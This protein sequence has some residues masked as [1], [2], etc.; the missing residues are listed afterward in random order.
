MMLVWAYKSRLAYKFGY[1]SMAESIYI[2]MESIAEAHRYSYNVA[3]YYHYGA[4][5]FYER[6]RETRQRKHTPQARKYKKLLE[7]IKRLGS[8]NVSAYLLFLNAVKASAQSG[9]NTSTMY[10]KFNAAIEAVAAE[11]LAAH[12]GV[13]ERT[14][15]ALRSSR[16]MLFLRQ[17]VSSRGR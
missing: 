3:S 6:Y 4:L 16:R 10:P 1:Y 2:D 14:R 17:R 11:K 7:Q 8:P 9:A 5:I 15:G 13:G 12:G